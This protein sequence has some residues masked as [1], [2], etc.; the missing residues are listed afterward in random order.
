MFLNSYVLIICLEK[1]NTAKR[2]SKNLSLPKPRLPTH[3]STIIKNDN[4][5]KIIVIT[6]K[7]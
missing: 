3:K 5:Q 1:T 2:L 4:L 6:K 7:V